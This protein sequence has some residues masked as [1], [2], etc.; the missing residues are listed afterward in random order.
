MGGWGGI[1]FAMRIIALQLLSK[2]KIAPSKVLKIATFKI[3][4]CHSFIVWNL[5]TKI[6]G[7]EIC[8]FTVYNS[9]YNEPFPTNN[10]DCE[11][12]GF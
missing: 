6:Y 4:I 5:E 2:L 1:S 7:A 9:E 11:V 10:R 12:F 3:E 8:R